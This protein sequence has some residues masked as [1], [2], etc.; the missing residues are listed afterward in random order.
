MP[1]WSNYGIVDVIL[2]LLSDKL[3]RIASFVVL[4]YDFGNMFITQ[5]HHLFIWPDD[6]CV[7]LTPCTMYVLFIENVIID[8]EKQSDDDA[9]TETNGKRMET[10]QTIR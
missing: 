3:N 8:D 7:T 2:S 4:Y 10:Q 5:S 1:K 9:M 6:G